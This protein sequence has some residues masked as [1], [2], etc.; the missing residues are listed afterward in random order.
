MCD[1]CG[2]GTDHVHLTDNKG[3]VHHL[4]P[5]V[6]EHTQEH[7]IVKA[8]ETPYGKRVVELAFNVLDK[9]NLQA[10]KNRTLLRENHITAFNLVSSPGSGKTTVLERTLTDLAGAYS[11]AVIEGDQQTSNDAARIRATATPAVQVN[12]GKGCHLDAGMVARAI[13][14]LAPADNSLLF[15]ENVGNL[16][17]PALFYLGETHRVVIL[18][19]TEG[20]DKP[21]K[22]P[23]MFRTA[24]ICIINKIDL[25]PYVPFDIEKCKAT[26]L[27]LQPRLQFIEMDA[28]H[29]VGMQPW[30]QLL[31][32]SVK[33]HQENAHV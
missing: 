26:A 27:R 8:A 20:D 15:I 24:D 2:C 31:E 6:S 9:N 22:Y 18:S 1:T 25:L 14:L 13:E 17:C 33:I 11:M 4:H 28:L 19:V 32:R 3:K 29:G 16:V 5:V 12:T 23:D 7:F 30:Y 21:E 10:E